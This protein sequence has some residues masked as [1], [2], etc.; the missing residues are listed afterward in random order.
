MKQTKPLAQHFICKPLFE[1]EPINICHEPVRFFRDLFCG[2]LWI[3]SFSILSHLFAF[4]LSSLNFQTLVCMSIVSV[5]S[6]V[7]LVSPNDCR[8]NKDA[9]SIK[10]SAC[11]HAA[12]GSA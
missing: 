6:Y 3:S 10:I 1:F 11:A 12:L 7:F 9:P 8:I 5:P 4:M 2:L